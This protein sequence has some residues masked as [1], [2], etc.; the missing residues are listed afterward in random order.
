LVLW[1]AVIK[2]LLANHVNVHLYADMLDRVNTAI[3]VLAVL[4]M[5]LIVGI[6]AWQVKEIAQKSFFSI[7]SKDTLLNDI[8]MTTVGKEERQ[9]RDEKKAADKQK[10]E[11][12]AAEFGLQLP[13][14]LARENPTIK[15]ALEII[16]CSDTVHPSIE[17]RIRF[18]GFVQVLRALKESPHKKYKK[19]AREE[20]EEEIEN[21]VAAA[22]DEALKQEG[23]DDEDEF[24]EGPRPS[25]A[26]S[27]PIHGAS[28]ETPES[29]Q[30]LEKR[31]I[32][33][34]LKGM[35]DVLVEW[36]YPQKDIVI[37]R[38]AGKLKVLGQEVLKVS[39]GEECLKLKW[40]DK[41][42]K[43][44]AELQTHANS[45]LNAAGSKLSRRRSGKRNTVQ[46]EPQG[47]PSWMFN[48]SRQWALGP[49][50]ASAAGNNFERR[51]TLGNATIVDPS[52]PDVGES[53]DTP[54]S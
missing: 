2:D 33:D 9:A 53:E 48:Q 20:E 19:P 37:D 43:N 40:L 15:K 12:I 46:A 25:V 30:K 21:L 38:E 7:R 10:L 49:L 6:P 4:L 18:R 51:R 29:R 35:R 54:S 41:G 31:A 42:Y 13:S 16:N 32:K 11:D 24:D 17:Q 14:T 47:E 3:D 44:W 27:Y 26:S 39:M 34:F 22:V 1:C 23:S 52:S 28:K 45:L 50:A 5:F 8:Y 36:G